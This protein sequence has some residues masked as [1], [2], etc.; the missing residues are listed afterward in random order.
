MSSQSFSRIF[1]P[2]LALALSLGLG[3]IKSSFHKTRRIHAES[4]SGSQLSRSTS[5]AFEEGILSPEGRRVSDVSG[6]ASRSGV[7]TE[8]TAPQSWTQ[9]LSRSWPRWRMLTSSLCQLRRPQFRTR[10]TFS[11][12]GIWE[13]NHRPSL[14]FSKQDSISCAGIQTNDYFFQTGTRGAFGGSGVGSGLGAAGS[15]MGSDRQ[16]SSVRHLGQMLTPAS[17]MFE[18]ASH[19]RR[20]FAN[21]SSG[22][23]G[24][25]ESLDLTFMA[26]IVSQENT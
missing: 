5:T 9:S 19:S 13:S 16:L 2:T 6:S 8:R 21:S 18:H 15:G 11:S 1:W 20:N 12:R 23:R 26:E 3:C 22:K 14:R 25:S 7:T 10:Q 24:M 17:Q 4:F